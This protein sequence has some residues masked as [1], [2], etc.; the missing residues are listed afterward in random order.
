MASAAS[1]APTAPWI[2]TGALEN[3]PDLV[4]Q[5]ARERRLWGNDAATLRAVRDPL[6]VAAALRGSALCC[7]AVRGDATGLPRDGSWLA[8]PVA[9]SGGRGVLVLDRNRATPRHEPYYYQER[10]DGPSFAALFIARQGTGTR[11]DLLGVTRQLL[12]R[13]GLPFAY[14]GSIGPWPLD[15][16]ARV[17]IETVGRTLAAAFSLVGLFG[18]DLILRTGIPWPVEVNPRYTASVEVLELAL[19]R[20]LLAEHARACEPSL[21]FVP[22]HHPAGVRPPL[23][24]KRVLFAPKRCLIPSGATRMGRKITPFAVPPRADIPE[25]QTRFDA[26]EPVMTLFARGWN[27][28]DCSRR[29]DHRLQY[30]SW[31]LQQSSEGV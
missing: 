18:V 23:V 28:T 1:T 14:A 26:G 21:D 24:G 4:A 25:P 11:A 15:P 10:I 13:P 8:K 5:I 29:L 27:V 17:R 12:G 2:Y 3:H 20:P 19:G 9:S 6:A 7:P 16:A 31:R 30:W 22:M